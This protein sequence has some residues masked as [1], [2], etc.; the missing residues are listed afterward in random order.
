M[1]IEGSPLGR[2][3]GGAAT[4]NREDQDHME[5][6]SITPALEELERAIAWTAR[7]TDIPAGHR[8]VPTIQTGGRRKGV[9]YG[10]FLRDGWSTREGDLCDEISFT[11]EQLHRPVEAIIET[12]VHEVAH[13]WARTLGLKDCSAAGRHN[14]VFK[15]HAEALGLECMEPWDSK[16][17]TYTSATP[18]LLARIASELQPD[19]AKFALFRRGE[20]TRKAPTRML[21]WGCGCTTVRCATA[22]DATCD[23]CG[24]VFEVV[25]V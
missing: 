18:E 6:T 5:I 8:I 19:V 4:R 20:G 3:T 1:T 11:A 22:L 10:W 17:Y 9:C 13:L 16:G 24:G 25:V 14:K 15:R 21:K 2:G 12:A 7:S 23:S